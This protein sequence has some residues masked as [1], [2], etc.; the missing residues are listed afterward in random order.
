MATSTAFETTQAVTTEPEPNCTAFYSVNGFLTAFI[1]VCGLFGNVL[2]IVVFWMSKKPSSTMY[3]ISNLAIVD[4]LVL[5]SFCP[6]IMPPTT[7]N[8]GAIYIAFAT[9][10]MNTLNQISIFFITIVVWQRY[11]SVCRPYAAKTWSSQRTLQCLTWGSVFLAV[12]MYMPGFFTQTLHRLPSGILYNKA[13]ALGR[14]QTFYIL[15]TS[16]TLNIF[17]L[18]IPIIILCYTTGGLIR[19]VLRSQASVGT[20]SSAATKVVKMDLTISLIV[21]VIVFIVCQSF[22]PVRY[23]LIWV[24]KPYSL[25]I[26]CGGPLQYWNISGLSII[27]N[28]SCNFV[29]YVL[30]AR[31][32]R[33]RVLTILCSRILSHKVGSDISGNTPATN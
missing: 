17:S 20:A 8:L 31:R 29:I 16:L 32:F 28:S 25:A 6:A 2:T 1:I 4:S 21:V 12:L 10:A 27:I 33:Q 15:H 9:N 7:K 13:T 23:I 14:N 22:R 19:S 3:S 5:L 18:V 11:V 26:A 24:F 30:C